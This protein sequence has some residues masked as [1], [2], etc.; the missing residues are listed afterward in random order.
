MNTYIT[1]ML[2]IFE[3]SLMKKFLHTPLILID[4]NSFPHTTLTTSTTSFISYRPRTHLHSKKN[5]I[6]YTNKMTKHTFFI[7]PIS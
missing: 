2:N 5:I 7:T 6:T 4:I 3:A 1:I